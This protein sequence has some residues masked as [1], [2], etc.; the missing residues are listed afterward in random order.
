MEANEQA[1]QLIFEAIGKVE[2][3]NNLVPDDLLDEA[4]DKLY[5]AMNLLA[6][7]M[8]SDVRTV[9]E[10]RLKNPT[11]DIDKWLELRVKDWKKEAPKEVGKD[12]LD[13]LL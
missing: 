7:D 10:D 8:Q 12:D 6:E 4:N 3:M 11:G 1:I 2:V 13:E 5:E 9:L